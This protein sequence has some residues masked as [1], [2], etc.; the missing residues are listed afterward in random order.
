MVG[1]RLED[2]K[3]VVFTEESSRE[4]IIGYS[5]A[6]QSTGLLLQIS[7]R[8][9]GYYMYLLSFVM[10]QDLNH[11]A[12]SENEARHLVFMMGKITCYLL[13]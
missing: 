11:K 3:I 12:S 6:I 8:I 9:H 13:F 4:A 7:A 10:A 5:E 1:L 2:V